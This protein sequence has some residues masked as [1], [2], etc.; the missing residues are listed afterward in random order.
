MGVGGA[1]PVLLAQHPAPAR[2]RSRCGRS[3]AC[4]E[5]LLSRLD[6]K[7]GRAQLVVM[8][9]WRVHRV[10][11]VFVEVQHLLDHSESDL[12]WAAKLRPLCVKIEASTGSVVHRSKAHRCIARSTS[13]W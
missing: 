4:W 13:A 11:E 9:H 5:P 7:H 12:T 10:G 8:D 6:V 2:A 1:A 3:V